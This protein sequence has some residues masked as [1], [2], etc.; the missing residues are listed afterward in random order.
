MSIELT[1]EF[2]AS[3]IMGPNTALLAEELVQDLELPRGSRILDLGCGKGVSSL[4]LYNRTPSTIFAA[5]LWITAT[6]NFE[7]FRKQGA[8]DRI[9][10][11]H[12]DALDMPFAHGY[13]D[14]LVSIDSY[15]YFGCEEGVIDAVSAYVKPGGEIRLAVPGMV[16]DFGDD[17]PPELLLSWTP[18][19]LESIR[20]IAWW[21]DLL[22]RSESIDIVSITEMA[23]FERAWDDWLASGNEYAQHDRAAMEAGA[24]KHMNLI[25][26]R[27]IKR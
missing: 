16:R 4:V 26:I 3:N 15:H 22:G 10:P 9:V 23:C 21:S 13:F 6:E 5:D 8:D 11:V 18:E 1:D 20:S 14:A 2:I 27:A 25:A 19:D 12:A 17:V 7:R 24:K